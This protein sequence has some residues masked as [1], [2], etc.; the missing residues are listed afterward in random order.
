MA[1]FIFNSNNPS[2]VTLRNQMQ[3]YDHLKRNN[4][5]LW[6]F[7]VLAL[8]YC[9]F[10]FLYINHLIKNCS[11]HSNQPYS[12]PRS[13][14][15]GWECSASRLSLRQAAQFTRAG[16]EAASQVLP[17]WSPC[18]THC[19]GQKKWVWRVFLASSP[20]V[21]RLSRHTHPLPKTHTELPGAYKTEEGEG[22]WRKRGR[23]EKVDPCVA[24]ASKRW[25]GFL[26]SPDR[27]PCYR[28]PAE[29]A[30]NVNS[31]LTLC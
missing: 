28:Q 7:G 5:S 29:E 1:L 11:H 18:S 13:N 16:F 31:L 22:R 23:P 8:F 20:T 9:H 14:A 17:T 25:D 2:Q 4:F 21:L 12:P 30:A 26:Q 3:K 10:S 6:V 19:T 24:V 27:E 15:P